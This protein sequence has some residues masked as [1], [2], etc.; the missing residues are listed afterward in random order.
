[1][2][3]SAA[4]A[5]TPATGAARASGHGLTPKRI[6]AML[7]LPASLLPVTLLGPG[8]LN[9]PRRLARQVWAKAVRLE[10]S[11]EPGRPHPKPVPRQAAEISLGKLY[12]NW[13]AFPQ[14]GREGLVRL[15][16]TR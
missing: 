16:P 14:P 10:R 11:F 12:G 5:P 1:M 7:V 4:D 8:E 2:T 6:L 3:G 9:A 15:G 13:H